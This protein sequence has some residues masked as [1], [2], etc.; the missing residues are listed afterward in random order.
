MELKWLLTPTFLC[1]ICTF[2]HIS[3]EIFTSQAAL[4]NLIHWEKEILK[5]VV[6]YVHAEE[7]KL[8]EMKQVISQV[9]GTLEKVIIGNVSSTL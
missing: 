4:E 6:N 1:V 3:S 8:R 7:E 9:E 2:R 5:K